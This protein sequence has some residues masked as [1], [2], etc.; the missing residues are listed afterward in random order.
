MITWFTIHRITVILLNAFFIGWILY[1]VINTNSDKSPGMFMITY[2]ALAFLNLLV[3]VILGL[4]KMKHFKI[5]REIF[6]GEL[7]LFIPL[8]IIV[9]NL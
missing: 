8:I 4:F 6:L 3:A 2:M 9:A 1:A 7:L 5:Y